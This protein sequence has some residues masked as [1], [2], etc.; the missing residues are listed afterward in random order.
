MRPTRNSPP[1]MRST[2][3]QQRRSLV[4]ARWQ[5][6]PAPVRTEQQ[7]AGRGGVACGA[8]WG[9]MEKCNFACSSCYLTELGNET[10][11][12]PFE[13]AAAQLRTLREHLGPAGKVQITSGE[14]TLLP[15]ED[16]GR[17][18]RYAL[19]LGLDPMV[20]TNGERFRRDEDYLFRLVADYGLR[21][22]SLHIDTTQTGRRWSPTDD[23]ARM[24][25]GL[26]EPDLH[27]L[28]DE[29]AAMVD[30]IAARAGVRMHVAHTVTVTPRTLD[31]IPSIVAWALRQR[32]FRLLSLLPAAPVGR[33]LDTRDDEMT[34]QGVW[35]R[36]QRG[37]GRDLNRDAVHFGHRE[38]NITT[39][40]LQLGD[41]G[42]SLVEVVR[43]GNAW[44]ARM[45][46][47]ML[48]ELPMHVDL[49][50]GAL[51]NCA[52]LLLRC[53]KRPLFGLRLAAWGAWRGLGVAARC[54]GMLLRGRLPRPHL[55]LL[56]VHKFMDQAELE[57]PL[58]QERLAGC[59][60]KLPMPDGRMVSMC[61]MNA[62]SL[63]HELNLTRAMR[64]RKAQ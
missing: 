64:P 42:R 11:P 45:V 21:K 47:A 53:L 31:D 23:R 59:V 25:E 26:A 20:M 60:F 2:E 46:S 30:R 61:E 49:D 22:L 8:T 54:T 62:T 38:C 7:L 16:L 32:T 44:D 39:P 18:V 51:R 35:Q 48:R 4:E 36:V 40:V 24:P 6:L 41:D 37:A 33:T 10:E 58:G 28:R 5:D 56:V 9:V 34:M 14:V 17:I 12:L 27:P 43:P 1:A 57:T 50:D 29:F 13:D 19:D 63:R 55:L 52:R 3:T 15:V